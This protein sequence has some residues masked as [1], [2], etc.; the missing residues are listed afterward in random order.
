VQFLQRAVGEFAGDRITPANFDRETPKFCLRYLS[1]SFNLGRLQV[2][3]Q[4]AFAMTLQRLAQIEWVSITTGGRHASGSEWMPLSNLDATDP[5]DRF[6]D[7]DRFLVLRYDGKL[8]M[9]GARVDDV[10]H[11]LWVAANFGELYKH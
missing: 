10:F 3:Q 1:S 11:V 2:K 6:G 8:P 5:P 4:A 9:V 7:R